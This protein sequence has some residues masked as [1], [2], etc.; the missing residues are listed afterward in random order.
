M[1]LKDF[2]LTADDLIPGNW[3]YGSNWHKDSF[4]RYERIDTHVWFNAYYMS[5]GKM[6]LRP[7]GWSLCPRYKQVPKEV[8]IESI[9]TFNPNLF[10][11]GQTVVFMPEIAMLLN[12]Y[13]S[14]CWNEPHIL[15]ILKMSGNDLV[16]NPA[17]MKASTVRDYIGYCSNDYR[18]FRFATNIELAS[19]IQSNGSLTGLVTNNSI[20]SSQYIGRTD[21]SNIVSL[22][23]VTNT[24][25]KLLNTSTY[26]E[27]SLVSNT[28]VTTHLIQRTNKS[29]RIKP[30]LI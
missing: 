21:V 23:T 14:G 9:S 5:Q 1:E 7:G 17:N 27:F 16:F 26:G 18:C 30:T 10:K 29:I 24:P 13:I 6:C 8:L 11:P 28:P 12:Y 4:V 25:N 15:Q 19:S 22:T 2:D 20:I 3:Y